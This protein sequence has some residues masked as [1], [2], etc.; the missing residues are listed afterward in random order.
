VDPDFRADPEF[1]NVAALVLLTGFLQFLLAFV[2]KFGKIRQL[3][4]WG[5]V[6]RSDFDEVGILVLSD[7]DRFLNRSDS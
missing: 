7:F 4:N 5:V 6:Q 3:A 2:A 1:L